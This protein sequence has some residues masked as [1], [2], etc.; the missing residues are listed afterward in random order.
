MPCIAGQLQ[1]YRLTAVA[2][3][4]QDRRAGRVAF[5]PVPP[6]HQRDQHRI[7]VEALVG[8]PVLLP[9]ALTVLLIGNLASARPAARTP[10]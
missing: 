9:A 7:Q 4:E 8:Q 2:V 5:V 10:A 3:R 1:P 6:V